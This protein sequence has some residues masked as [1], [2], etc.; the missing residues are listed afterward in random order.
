MVIDVTKREIN[1]KIVY[2]G[3]AVSGKTTN[4]LYI[5][6][7][8]KPQHRGEMVSIDTKGERTL[9]FD[10][11]PVEV[12]IG[13]GFKVR[14]HLYTVPGQY[15]YKTSRKLVLRGADGI[16]FVADS[17]RNR[18]KDNRMIWQEMKDFLRDQGISIGSIP[19]V[20]QY[21]K[22]DLQDIMSVEELH[23]LFDGG[24]F[25]YFEAIAVQGKGVFETL[26]AISK[27]VLRSVLQKAKV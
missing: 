21:N 27:R 13:G 1:V 2:Y 23:A 26:D 18:A 15:F 16:V 3:P 9:F 17:Q 22:R 14:F 6:S 19:I 25:P 11:L 7:K 8:L 20:L 5:H 10:F 12:K 24:K 4:L